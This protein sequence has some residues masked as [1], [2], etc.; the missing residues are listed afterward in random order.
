MVFLGLPRTR[1]AVA[2]TSAA[3]S[4]RVADAGAGRWRAWSSASRRR[5]CWPLLATRA[6]ARGS[7]RGRA[8]PCPAPLAALG[9]IQRRP[10]AVAV[11][12]AAGLC[13]ARQ[14]NGLERAVTWDCGYAAPTPRMQYTA[15]SFAAIITAWFAWILRPERHE[16]PLA[17]SVPGH[18]SFE[19]HTPETVLEH[20]VEPAGRRVMHRGRAGAPAPARTLAGLRALRR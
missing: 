18:A 14:H 19:E 11:L 10:R 13:G 2:R 17:G 6:P 3:G 8:S 9:G 20:V 16:R 4:M 7:R 5:C 12:A 1:G 15:G